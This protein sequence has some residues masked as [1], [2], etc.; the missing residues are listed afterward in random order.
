MPDHQAIQPPVFTG[1]S[2]SAGKP[3]PAPD[4]DTISPTLLAWVC[5]LASLSAVGTWYLDNSQGMTS[6]WE[7]MGA[8]V[9]GVIY[10]LTGLWLFLRPRWLTPLMAF[11]MLVTGIY[12]LGCLHFATLDT[13]DRGL[14]TF[15]S[16]AQ[17]M[18]MLYLGAFIS[19]RNSAATLCWVHY[20]GLVTVYLLHYGLHLPVAKDTVGHTWIV[21]LLTHPGYILALH[22]IATLKGRLRQSERDAQA[23]KERFLAMLSH[24]IRSPLQAMLGSIDL[25][26]L[27]VQSPPE[28]RAVDR[29]RQSAAQLD[30]H[31]RDVM[32]YT[33]LENPAWQLQLDTVDL[34]A[35]VRDVCDTYQPQAA[36]KGLRIYCEISPDDDKALRAVCTDARRTRQILSNLITN[37]IKYT[38][39]G[40]VGVQASR[41]PGSDSFQ[42]EV[43]DTGIGIPSDEF[44]RIFE[45]YVRLEDRRTEGADGSGLGLAV[46]QRLIDRL[47][48]QLQLTSKL[49]VGSTFKVILPM[50]ARQ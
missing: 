23:S 35:L 12:F 24:E 10:G 40:N 27:K 22:Y 48:G 15:S 26:G 28:R 3:L 7:D 29:L 31:L 2:A 41:L 11:A 6:A 5:L 14:Y 16:N 37:A 19:M 34:S 33:R 42:L 18:P 20:T 45:P 9:L 8:P 36:S 43:S 17:F 44:G 32:E 25:L 1:A 38:P 13:S 50:Q 49:D 4:T 47:G 21:L 30:A 46:V 39:H